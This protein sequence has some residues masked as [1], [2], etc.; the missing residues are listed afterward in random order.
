MAKRRYGSSREYYSGWGQRYFPP[1]TPI[2]AV[3]GI[4]ARSK[5]GEFGQSWWAKRWI[6][7]LNGFNLGARLD[8]GR[9][10]ARRG[11]VLSIE[12]EPG[13]VKAK[14]QGSRPQPYD[15]TI[16]TRT[17]SVADRKALGAELASQ[18]IFAAKLLAGEMP[19]EVEDVF[20][21]AGLSVFPSRVS[22]LTTECSCPDWSNPCKHVAAVYYLL[23]EEFDRDPFLIFTLR[24]LPREEFVALLGRAG[25][26][27][28]AVEAAPPTPT[29]PARV[30]EPLPTSLAHFFT[31]KPQSADPLGTVEVP[32]TPATLVR[33]LGAFPFWRGNQPLVE[34]LESAYRTASP[35]GLEV[36]LGNP[37]APGV[38]DV[39]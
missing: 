31:S 17:L 9:N 10:Y 2:Q 14:V 15:V 13:V 6:D 25:R 27:A 26:K 4:K 20:K 38:S 19:H 34:A 21:A 37:T 33:R 12:I 35:R 32:A 30:S 5:A 1:S 8:R 18:A 24:G 16:H 36:V 23:G 11:Q 7:V 39:K 3:G 22:D 29:P 28:K